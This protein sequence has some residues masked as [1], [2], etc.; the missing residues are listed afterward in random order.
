[1]YVIIY[2]DYNL[3]ATFREYGFT[4]Q[5]LNKLFL[6]TTRKKDIEIDCVCPLIFT[7]DIFIKCLKNEI[8][9]TNFIKREVIKNEN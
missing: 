3:K 5:I 2:N 7:I 9:K 1:M 6:L 4:K 8:I